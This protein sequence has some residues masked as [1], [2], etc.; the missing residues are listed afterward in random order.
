MQKT[1]VIGNQLAAMCSCLQMDLFLGNQ[2][3]KQSSVALSTTEA[4]YYAMGIT[5]QEAVWIRQLCEELMLTLEAP[6]EIYS[7]NTGAV[8]L[9]GN[10]VYHRRSKH[11][12]I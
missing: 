11:I 10:P 7:D 12:D 1:H 5:C 8:A 6:L 9:S 4:E 2:K 3:K